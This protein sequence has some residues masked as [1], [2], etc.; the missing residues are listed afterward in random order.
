MWTH[1]NNL[2]KLLSFLKHPTIWFVVLF[3][4]GFFRMIPGNNFL[5]EMS[6]FCQL[7]NISHN[8]CELNYNKIT[9]SENHKV[10]PEHVSCEYFWA[11]LIRS[12]Y[13]LFIIQLPKQ[14]T[15]KLINFLIT[16]LLNVH[17]LFK[18]YAWLSRFK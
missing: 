1:W 5:S 2:T 4:H 13:V 3:A 7:S 10:C 9:Q 16:F 14:V 11:K 17:L 8:G 12:Y 6:E 15:E 18:L